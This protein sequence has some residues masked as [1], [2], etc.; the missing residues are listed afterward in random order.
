MTV[1]L[2]TCRGCA[3]PR[4]LTEDP[5]RPGRWM[6]ATTHRPGCPRLMPVAGHQCPAEQWVP[7]PGAAL[8][9]EWVL[10]RCT[11]CNAVRVEHEE[12]HPD[13]GGSSSPAGEAAVS[14]SGSVPSPSRDP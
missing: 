11:G 13:P 6:I 7:L 1:D 9:L 3:A 12:P 2:G 14:W 8:P 4:V 10:E 5:D